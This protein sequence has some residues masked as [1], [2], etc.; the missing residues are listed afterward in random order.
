MEVSGLHSAFYNDMAWVICDDGGPIVTVLHGRQLSI[1][2]LVS[3]HH[4]QRIVRPPFGKELKPRLT[5]A[6]KPISPDPSP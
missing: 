5:L 2:S 3:R 1:K 6:G 4:I